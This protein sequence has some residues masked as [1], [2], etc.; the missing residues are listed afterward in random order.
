MKTDQEIVDDCN[1]LARIFYA[2][3]GCQV[4]SVYHFDRATH[5]QERGMWNLAVL[6][7][8]FI[9]GTSVEDALSGIEE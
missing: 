4:P 3:Q 8:D 9:E 1:K 5:P 7:Y 6:A 2:S